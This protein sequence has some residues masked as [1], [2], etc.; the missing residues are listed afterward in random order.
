MLYVGSTV[1]E[2]ASHLSKTTPTICTWR[3]HLVECNSPEFS[4]KQTR[5]IELLFDD[6]ISVI[7]SAVLTQ[8]PSMLDGQIETRTDRYL[9]TAQSALCIALRGKNW[10]ITCYSNSGL[11]RRQFLAPNDTA[12]NVNWTW[13]VWKWRSLR[14]LEW[15]YSWN[16]RDTDLRTVAAEQGK[17]RSTNRRCYSLSYC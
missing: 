7:Y 4:S 13:L 17:T 8:Y 15:N 12:N 14:S 9:V 3:F 11:T 6:R 16:V 5:T 2:T 1:Y 10:S